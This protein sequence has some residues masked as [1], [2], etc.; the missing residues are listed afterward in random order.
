MSEHSRSNRPGIRSTV[1]V[2]VSLLA[3]GTSAWS[4]APGWIPSGRLAFWTDTS[5]VVTYVTDN[6]P[7]ARAGVRVGDVV[8]LAATPP[9]SRF[10][11]WLGITERAGDRVTIGLVHKG[12]LQ[13]VTVTSIP[14]P[15]V[16]WS[17]RAGLF[18][19]ALLFVAL[20]SA[21]VLLRPSITTWGFY[22]YCI[23]NYPNHTAAILLLPG[24]WDYIAYNIDILRQFAGS[25]GLLIFAICFLNE[26]MRGTRL[27]ALR[28]MSWL[29]IGLA[30][31]VFALNYAGTWLGAPRDLLYRINWLLLLMIALVT[32]LPLVATYVQSRDAAKQ[33]VRWLVVAFGTYLVLFLIN[34]VLQNWV[35]S[36]PNWI[37]TLLYFSQ[38]IIPITVAYAVIKHRVIDVSFVISRTIVLTILTSFVVIIFALIDFIFVHK[39]EQT[40]LGIISGIAA[41][42]AVAFTSR[43]MHNRVDIWVDRS[44]FKR[45]YAAEQKL[46]QVAEELPQTRTPDEFASRLVRDPQEAL[47][48]ASAALFQYSDGAFVREQ[49]VGWPSS[50]LRALSATDPPLAALA[51]M[52]ETKR[53]RWSDPNERERL[54][55]SNHPVLAMPIIVNN[56]LQAVALYGLHEDGTDLDPDE[57]R[58]IKGLMLPATAAEAQLEAKRARHEVE[59]LRLAMKVRG[60]WGPDADSSDEPEISPS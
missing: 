5:N 32:I 6:S 22:F 10:R 24:P 35:P 44:F 57:I 26:P 25:V 12:S 3:I 29:S 38:V 47:K 46:K 36:T 4:L 17:V 55:Q 54:P 34:N 20:G 18:G 48:L 13:M 23:G 31:W 58:A 56:T 43:A 30:I 1:V 28:L 50:A 27:T 49:A 15:K 59:R 16:P 39:L 41:A 8:D 45:R 52:R 53:I 7:A 37:I 9:G 42:T 40:G 60:Q 11:A 19:I 21:L 2:A 33:R 14:G 51:G